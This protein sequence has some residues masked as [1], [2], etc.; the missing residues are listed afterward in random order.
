M[1]IVVCMHSLQD[2]LDVLWYFVLEF[3]GLLPIAGF[4]SSHV[5]LYVA[6][7]ELPPRLNS[8]GFQESWQRQH[9]I[10]RGFGKS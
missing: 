4:V 3:V 8:Y 5:K 2:I 6:W 9:M 7:T 1:H 10:R